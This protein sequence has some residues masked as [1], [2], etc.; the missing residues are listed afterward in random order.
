MD[1]KRKKI[2]PPSEG[3]IGAINIETYAKS[4]R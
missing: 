4:L 1:G 2:L 3:G